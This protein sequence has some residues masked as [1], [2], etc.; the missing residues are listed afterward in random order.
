MKLFSFATQNENKI[1]FS[2]EKSKKNGEIN[3][4]MSKNVVLYNE[5]EKE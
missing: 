2:K 5:R 4:K 3:C 1:L